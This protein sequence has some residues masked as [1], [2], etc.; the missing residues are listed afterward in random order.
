MT[1]TV[2]Q[3]WPE[4]LTR[5]TPYREVRIG[6]RTWISPRVEELRGA[7][8][9]GQTCHGLLVIHGA[10]TSSLHGAQSYSFYACPVVSLISHKLCSLC[11]CFLPALAEIQAQGFIERFSSFKQSHP[12]VKNNLHSPVDSPKQCDSTYSSEPWRPQ[13]RNHWSPSHLSYNNCLSATL[14][15]LAPNTTI[16][17]EK[18]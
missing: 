5:V 11:S 16:P 7:L 3:W 17:K 18:P 1:Q 12:L 9:R 6:R 10:S 13:V 4:A 15:Y 14:N 8:E 2:G